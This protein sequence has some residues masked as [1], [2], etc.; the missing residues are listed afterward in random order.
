MRVDQGIR[1]GPVADISIQF[2]AAPDELFSFV[3]EAWDLRPWTLTAMRFFPFQAV[4]I[5]RD[6]LTAWFTKSSDFSR[7]AFTL[8]KPT[9][10]ASDGLDF[11]TKN[12]HHLRLDCGRRTDNGLEQS[13]LSARTD[14]PQSLA[15]WRRVA[16]MLK[17]RTV[18]GVVAVNRSSGATAIIKSFRYSNGA[19]AL[20]RDGVVILPP[21]GPNGPRLILGTAQ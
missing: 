20:E 12:A 2:H 11:A 13:W 19:R 15:A 18:A 21:Q 10:P 14:H 17:R 16:T 9:L 7:L 1:S 6:H 5:E 3:E 4:E 8:G